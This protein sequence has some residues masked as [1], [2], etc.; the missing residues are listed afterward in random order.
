MSIDELVLLLRNFLFNLFASIF[1]CFPITFIKMI[2][3]FNCMPYDDGKQPFVRP[4]NGD[5]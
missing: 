1:L 3:L 4:I 5:I 2:E